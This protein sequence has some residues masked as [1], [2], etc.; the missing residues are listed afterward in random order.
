MKSLILLG[1][2]DDT[3][4]VFRS[5]GPGEW[6][7]GLVVVVQETMQEVFEILFGPLHAVRQALLAKHAEEALNQVHP[8]SMRGGV[9]KLDLRMAAKP[10][11]RRFILVDV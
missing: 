2:L 11:P 3:L 7:A 4:Q 1:R 9:V 6:V 8:G 5:L 10:S